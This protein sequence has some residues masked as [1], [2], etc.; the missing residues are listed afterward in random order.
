LGRTTLL[1]ALLLSSELG[2][3]QVSIISSLILMLS[4]TQCEVA[5]QD[6]ATGF[7][8]VAQASGKFSNSKIAICGMSG[9]FPGNV[10]DAVGTEALWKIL[11]EGLDVHKVIPPDRFNVETHYDP[12]G[13]KLNTSHTQYGCFIEKPGLF[14]ARYFSMSPREAA[15]T[16]PMHRL[17]LVT[18]AEAL[19]MSGFVPNR[20]PS[21]HVSRVGTFYGQTSDDW[22]EVN[23]AQKIDTYFIPAGVRAFAPGRINYFFKFSGPSYSVDTACSSSLAAIQIA[24]TSLWAGE[25]DTAIAGGVNVLTAP[26]IFAGLSRG[27]FLSKTGGCKTFD[28]NADGYCR[29]DG[30]GTVILK[31]LG[32]LVSIIKRIV[33]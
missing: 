25:C 27:M 4:S 7:T 3:I 18:A 15:Q 9:R 31:R 21:S 2:I 14:D 16:D 33:S 19:E 13:K 29:A 30:V 20:T 12:T 10:G 22:R 6:L 26:D 17:A 28:A 32:E 23:I 8:T 5:L 24:C 1:G 11:E